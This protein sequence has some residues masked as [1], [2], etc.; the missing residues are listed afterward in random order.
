MEGLLGHTAG[1][2]QGVQHDDSGNMCVLIRLDQGIGTEICIYECHLYNNFIVP[3]APPYQTLNSNV[4]CYG[5]AL[6]SML[7]TC[8]RQIITS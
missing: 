4:N 7:S 8:W 2:D 5:N 6:E 1:Q 3:V